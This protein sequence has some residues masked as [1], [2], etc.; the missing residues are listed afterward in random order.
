MDIIQLENIY[1]QAQKKSHDISDWEEKLIP[2]DDVINFIQKNT[3]EIIPQYHQILLMVYNDMGDIVNR[4]KVDDNLSV[5]YYKN[6]LSFAADYRDKMELCRKIAEIYQSNNDKE[7]YLEMQ[8]RLKEYQKEL[9]V[10]ENYVEI[11][12]NTHNNATKKE[13]LEKA[14]RHSSCNNSRECRPIANMLGKLK[15]KK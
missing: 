5:I 8:K 4:V 2:Y 14:W 9:E 1:K 3:K 15:P 6:A 12:E 10:V 7:N 11:A 13:I